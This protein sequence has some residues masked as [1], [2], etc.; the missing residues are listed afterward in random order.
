MK[1]DYCKLKSTGD[2]FNKTYNKRFY[3]CPFHYRKA[4]Y[5]ALYHKKTEFPKSLEKIKMLTFLLVVN[6]FFF[7]VSALISVFFDSLYFSISTYLIGAVWF[8]IDY[9]L[10]N[11]KMSV[12]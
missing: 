7:I 1:C 12:A 2:V 11:E 5:D 8:Y 10:D 6:T 3:H 9:L 4:F